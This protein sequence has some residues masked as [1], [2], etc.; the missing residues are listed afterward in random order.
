ML[1]SLSFITLG[2]SISTCFGK[3]APAPNN[4]R[5]LFSVPA[6]TTLTYPPTD[7]PGPQP[8]QAWI[9]A[10]QRAKKAGLIPSMP[11]SQNVDGAAVY[12]ASYHGE[13]CNPGY[14]S[15]NSS[16]DAISAPAG[17]AGISFDDGPQ[18]PSQALL[19]FLQSQSQKA[20]HF[21]IG[22]RIINNPDIFRALDQA[23]Q[24]LAVH[25]FSHPL[26]TSL[27]DIQIVGELGWTMQL[28]HD[29]SSNKVV[30]AHWRPP[31][32]D[33]DQRVQAIAKHVF[34]LKSILWLYDPKDWCLAESTPN[35]SACSPGDGPQS[36]SELKRTLKAFIN[37]AKDKGLIILEHEQSTRAVSAFKYIFPLMK[38]L[39]IQIFQDLPRRWFI[40]RDHISIICYGQQPF[41]TRKGL[42]RALLILI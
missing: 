3:S 24:H 9:D 21:L 34:G 29:W 28:I 4:V 17:V 15:C 32:G 10:Y 42:P 6:G 2:L 12:P 41:P 40:C 7:V 13:I 16:A 37:S 36:L 25:T 39:R 1:L 8:R 19:E 11:Q 22:S 5:A 38:K 31:Y 23:G 26:M 33:T 35:A 30:C 20:T 18:P 14:N 27:S